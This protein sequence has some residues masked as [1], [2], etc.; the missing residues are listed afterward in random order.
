MVKEDAVRVQILKLMCPNPKGMGPNWY[1]IQKLRYLKIVQQDNKTSFLF[2]HNKR[3][4]E[5][6]NRAAHPF[7]T[8][9]SR[10]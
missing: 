1:R 9:E 10:E 8:H 5:G 3:E 7:L 6:K 2:S 4:M